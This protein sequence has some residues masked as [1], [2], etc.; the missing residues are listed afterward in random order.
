MPLQ[1]TW[2]GIIRLRGEGS[3]KA[4]PKARGRMGTPGAVVLSVTSKPVRLLP[5]ILEGEN[6]VR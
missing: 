1:P 6:S 4:S 3:W 2:K 5:N